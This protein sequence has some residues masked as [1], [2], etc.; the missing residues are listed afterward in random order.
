MF[1]RT[2]RLLPLAAALVIVLAFWL[3]NAAEPALADG[4]A[5][6]STSMSSVASGVDAS[7]PAQNLGVAGQS[8]QPGHALLLCVALL[9]AASLTVAVGRRRPRGTPAMGTGG[10]TYLARAGRAL[11]APPPHTYGLLRI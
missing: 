2:S 7:G 1:V 11:R 4:H 9:L 6:G 5:S 10:P 8:T 3:H